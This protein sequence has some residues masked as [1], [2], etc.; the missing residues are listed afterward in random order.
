MYLQE[1]DKRELYRKWKK[2]LNHFEPF[3]RSSPFVSLQT[4]S[5]IKLEDVEIDFNYFEKF[6]EDN[7][8][9]HLKDTS[10]LIIDLPLEK[11]LNISIILN[12]KYKFKPILNL[13]FLFHPYGLIG[14]PNLVN[15]FIYSSKELLEI[16]PKG[17]IMMIDYN[18]YGDYSEKL[19]EER[20]NNQYE[21]CDYDL[22]YGNSLKSLGYEEIVYIF[23]NKEKEDLKECLNYLKEEIPVNFIKVGK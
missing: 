16:V 4:Y 1:I 19:H 5:N 8:L 6:I 21:L 13:N 2:N 15:Q 17:Y 3:L 22:P 20:L 14:N 11:I 9:S 10:F 7:I 23:E 18:R 12:N